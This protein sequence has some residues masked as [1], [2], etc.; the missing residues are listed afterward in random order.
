MPQCHPCLL[1]C[2]WCWSSCPLLILKKNEPFFFFTTSNGKKCLPWGWDFISGSSR[3]FVARM[4][5]RRLFLQQEWTR[6]GYNYGFISFLSQEN[7]LISYFSPSPEPHLHPSPQWSH[8]TDQ[9][10]RSGE[11][12][13]CVQDFDSTLPSLLRSYTARDWAFLSVKT[14]QVFRKFTPLLLEKRPWRS[15]RVSHSHPQELNVSLPSSTSETLGGY[16]VFLL[17]NNK[18]AGVTGLV[19]L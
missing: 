18:H 5:R 19:D 1:L 3:V 6:L 11:V 2:K 16:D 9:A 15:L 13:L 17:Q 4:G 7:S 14:V 8:R 12:F 10:E